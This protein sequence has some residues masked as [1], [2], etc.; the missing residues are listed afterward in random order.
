MQTIEEAAKEFEKENSERIW[1]SNEQ[2]GTALCVESF[3]AGVEFAQRWIPVEEEL[4][5]TQGH[6]FVIAPESFPKNCKVVVAEFYE[7]NQIFY[8]ES[9]DCP[10]LDVTHW[11]PIELK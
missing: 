10:M 2:Q 8:S 4:P 11:R 7:D 5:I 1:F 9:S 3:K 6:Y